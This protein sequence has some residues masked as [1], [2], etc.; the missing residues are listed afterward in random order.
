MFKSADISHTS[1]T[2]AN[3]LGDGTDDQPDQ[4]QIRVQ[5]PNQLYEKLHRLATHAKRRT[6]IYSDK[7]EVF[8]R[9]F[10]LINKVVPEAQENSMVLNQL[11]K[12]IYYSRR[13]DAS[14]DIGNV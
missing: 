2:I 9:V 10:Q 6:V 5:H 14:Q 7:F 1:S 13:M 12:E 4:I 8:D 3:E 11:R